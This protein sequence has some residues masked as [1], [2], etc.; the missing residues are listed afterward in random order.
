LL[1]FQ[2]VNPQHFVFF[3]LYHSGVLNRNTSVKTAFVKPGIVTF[4]RGNKFFELS[5]HLGN[6]LVTVSDRMIVVGAVV[7]GPAAVAG[8]AVALHGLGVANAAVD[9]IIWSMKQL[10]KLNGAVDASKSAKNTP[11]QNTNNQ[12]T[13]ANSQSQE[14]AKSNTATKRK[15]TPGDKSF[16]TKRAARREAERNANVVTSR[17]RNTKPVQDPT[18]TNKQFKVI[19][20][21]DVNNNPVLIKKHPKH[22]FKDNNT[23]EDAH[24]HGQDGQ[25]YTYPK[26]N[27]KGG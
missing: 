4:N 11:A 22:E 20:T 8:G 2:K 26:K 24:Y 15:A 19:E 1:L 12:A 14:P 16:P 21:K 7:G 5:N 25:H 9:D 10:A 27:S 17:P 6:V 3:V 18:S 13:S 23:Y